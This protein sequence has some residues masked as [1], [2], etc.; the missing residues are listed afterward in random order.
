MVLVAVMLAIGDFYK[1]VGKLDNALSLYNI[2]LKKVEAKEIP[3]KYAII[4][5]VTNIH[6]WNK[7]FP[8]ALEQY[9]YAKSG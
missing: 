2:A 1:V 4:C 5:L 7:R 6:F 8:I 3:I 9:I